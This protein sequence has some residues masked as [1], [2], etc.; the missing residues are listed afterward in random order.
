V[1]GL[2]A[3]STTMPALGQISGEGGPIRVKADRS[4][5]LDK[6]KKVVLINN[7]DITQGGARLRADRVV[8]EYGASGST[9]TT[10]VGSGFGDINRMTATGEVFYITE[11]LKAKGDRGV[12]VANENTI[13]LT[14][15][16]ILL[17]G[18]DVG[19]GKRLTMDLNEGRTILRG[20]EGEQVSIVIVPSSGDETP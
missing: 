19:T 9:Q 11:D 13:T 10:G 20:Q 18:E 3:L 1:A 4:E 12:Y 5:V 2:L 15:E 8:I 6:E 17:R 14:G 7:V 16:V